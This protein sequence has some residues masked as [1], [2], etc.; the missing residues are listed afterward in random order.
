MWQLER[1]PVLS[2]VRG[3]PLSLP[4]GRSLPHPRA[5]GGSGSARSSL[6][7]WLGGGDRGI[8]GPGPVYKPHLPVCQPCGRVATAH[9]LTLTRVAIRNRGDGG[10]PLCARAELMPRHVSARRLAPSV[11]AQRITPQLH[12]AETQF[13][14]SAS[15]TPGPRHPK[16]VT[17]CMVSTCHRTRHEHVG[18]DS[19]RLAVGDARP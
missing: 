7:S 15:A 6:V 4:Q 13:G 11:R 1:P 5:S 17:G 19:G 14:Q 16:T 12:G 3:Q 18:S 10:G 8:M 9:S 2:S